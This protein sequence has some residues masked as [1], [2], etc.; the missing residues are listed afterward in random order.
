MEA[1]HIQFIE[2]TKVFQTTLLNFLHAQFLIATEF[3]P[4]Q[5]IATPTAIN[6]AADPSVRAGK[7]EDV[8]YSSN[9]ASDAFDWNTP[10][11]HPPSP[12]FQT[13]APPS[14]ANI[15][16]SSNAR[17][18]KAPTAQILTDDHSPEPTDEP[19]PTKQTSPTKRQRRYHIITSDTQDEG[20]NDKPSS[21]SLVF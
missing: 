1:Q 17:K 21:L 4:A 14:L 16:E 2:E 5:P 6:S 18:R 3:F 9:A 11:E 15:P 12:P 20:S 10:F 19:N 7:I 8:H 13:S